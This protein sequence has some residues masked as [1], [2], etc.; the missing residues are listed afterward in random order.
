MPDEEIARFGKR[1]REIRKHL[2]CMQK[3]FASGIGI[4]GSFLSEVEKGKTKAGYEFFR[5]IARKYNVNPL[6]LLG[7]SEEMFLDKKQ[8]IKTGSNRLDFGDDNE[9]IMEMLD[10]MQKFSV[11]RYTLLGFFKN[12]IFSKREMLQEE[13]KKKTET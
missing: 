4:S 9:N 8:G 6:F 3:E 5:G 13:L 11:V 7:Y 10:Y 1:V 12:Y 2:R